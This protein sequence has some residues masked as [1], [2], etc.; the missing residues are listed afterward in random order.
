[1]KRHQTRCAKAQWEK[2]VP[3]PIQLPVF[4]KEKYMKKKSTDQI[5]TG[6]RRK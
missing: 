2:P 1:M 5:S 4:L 3:I 6:S